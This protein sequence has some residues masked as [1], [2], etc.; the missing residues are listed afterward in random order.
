MFYNMSRST[1]RQMLELIPKKVGRERASALKT[2]C[3]CISL[4]SVFELI[5]KKCFR[6]ETLCFKLFLQHFKVHYKT[7][8]GIN[9]EESQVGGCFGPMA[10]WVC[11]IEKIPQAERPGCPL[12]MEESVSRAGDIGLDHD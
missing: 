4:R 3:K 11:P 10:L 2:I 6:R 9:F 8:F 5:F 7:N 1:L 12:H